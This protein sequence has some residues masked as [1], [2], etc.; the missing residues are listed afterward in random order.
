MDNVYAQN[1]TDFRARNRA[2]SDGYLAL[3][4][5]HHPKKLAPGVRVPR[6]SDLT[7]KIEALE[8]RIKDLSGANSDLEKKSDGIEKAAVIKINLLEKQLRKAE[9]ENERLVLLADLG[10][11]PDGRPANKQIIE[12]VATYYKRTLIEMV[13]QCRSREITRPRQ[14]AIYLCREVTGRSFPVIARSFG[15]RDHTTALYSYKTLQQRLLVDDRLT[16]DVTLLRLRIAEK[17]PP[18]GGAA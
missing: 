8:K 14:V 1:E 17:Y 3:V 2:A 6:I 10:T 4:A 11:I 13:G 16:D 15:D 5:Q 9:K 18:K 12:I 7:D